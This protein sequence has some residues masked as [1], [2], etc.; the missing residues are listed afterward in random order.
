VTDHRDPLER[1]ARQLVDESGLSWTNAWRQAKTE[2]GK[3]DTPNPERSCAEVC[4]VVAAFVV[5]LPLA[6]I[7]AL[8]L[9]GVYAGQIQDIAAVPLILGGLGVGLPLLVFAIVSA[10]VAW[11]RTRQGRP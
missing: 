8:I 6:T 3:H 1:R 7:G 5:G 9:W 4:G 2:V 11:Q 10:F